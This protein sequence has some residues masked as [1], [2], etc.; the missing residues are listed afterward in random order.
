MLFISELTWPA[1]LH[2]RTVIQEIMHPVNHAHMYTDTRSHAHTQTH[3]CTHAQT[4]ARA[5][6]RTRARAHARTHALAHARTRT[7]TR[8][9]TH[10]HT[11]THTHL[12]NKK[13]FKDD[14]VQRPP[15]ADGA[16]VY[17]EICDTTGRTGLPICNTYPNK[18]LKTAK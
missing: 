3:A 17:F 12:Q 2:G 15:L 8:T 5:H 9:R 6:A 16:H 10:T 7:R 1:A 11:H 4:H 18:L 13:I 14:I